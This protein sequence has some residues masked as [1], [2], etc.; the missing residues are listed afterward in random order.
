M[1]K[2][3]FTFTAIAAMM[4]GAAFAQMNPTP[5]PNPT[6]GQTYEA[7]A[8]SSIA[9]AIQLVT[10][11]VVKRKPS[12]WNICDSTP[13]LAGINLATAERCGGHNASRP[14]GPCPDPEAGKHMADLLVRFCRCN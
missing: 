7:G 12:T 3:I 13:D 9:P 11:N 10:G 4:A 6:Q 2:S 5:N 1:K 8:D 14:S